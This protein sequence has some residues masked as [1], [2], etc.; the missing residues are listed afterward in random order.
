MLPEVLQLKLLNLVGDGSDTA[1]VAQE[2]ILHIMIPDGNYLYY[3]VFL[4]EIYRKRT[5]SRMK[6]DF[7]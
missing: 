7:S 4:E 3:H 6:E 1:C 5:M 2:S